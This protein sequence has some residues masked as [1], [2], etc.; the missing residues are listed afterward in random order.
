MHTQVVSR[1]RTTLFYIPFYDSMLFFAA[2]IK[3]ML[4]F[5]L[6]FK[7]TE[8]KRLRKS[9]QITQEQLSHTVRVFFA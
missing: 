6:Y 1:L 4:F 2:G 9:P 5:L 7:D 3:F 8:R